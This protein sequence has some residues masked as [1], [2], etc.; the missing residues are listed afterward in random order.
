MGLFA[1]PLT[2]LALGV[3]CLCTFVLLVLASTLAHGLGVLHG[4]PQSPE[5][6]CEPAG[7]STSSVRTIRTPSSTTTNTI[8]VSLITSSK[9][10]RRSITGTCYSVRHSHGHAFTTIYD[11]TNYLVFAAIWFMIF[12]LAHFLIWHQRVREPDLF[13]KYAFIAFNVLTLI[14][15]VT[16]IGV[17]SDQTALRLWP[18]T[19]IML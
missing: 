17:G 19:A 5:S 9:I 3:G 11:S 15:L 18:I 14:F 16:G 8:A 7:S 12:L 6:Y 13:S 1:S 4:R 10:H 2:K